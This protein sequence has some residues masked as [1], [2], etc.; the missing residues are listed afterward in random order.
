MNIRLRTPKRDGRS[1]VSLLTEYADATP[2]D[3]AIEIEIPSDLSTL[4]DA[5]LLELHTNAIQAFNDAYGDGTNLPADTMAALK[6]LTLGI[7]SLATERDQRA[8]AAVALAV[9]AA[10]LAARV[11][12]TSTLSDEADEE[13]ATVDGETLAD[14]AL[15]EAPAEEVVLVETLASGP[16]RL[17]RNRVTPPSGNAL[18]VKKS[19]KDVVFAA[20]DDF[21]QVAS[22]GEG[23]DYAMLG[24]AL[25]ERLG[26]F[27]V[28]PYENA[29]SMHR[30][31]RSVQ[32]FARIKRNIP[33]DLIVRQQEF[34][35]VNEVISRAT[36][37]KRLKGGSLV[38][39]GGWHAPS[40]ILY[41]EFLTLESRDGIMSLPEVGVTR[42]GLQITPGPSFASL[43]AAIPGFYVSEAAD[44]AGDYGSTSGGD[45][46]GNK[47]VYHVNP[48]SFTDYRLGVSGLIIQ[49]G[50][51]GARG[52]PE[53]LARV[54][55]GALVAHD[56]RINFDVIA[57]IASLST[58]VTLPATATGQAGAAAPVLTA[59]E[60]QVQHYR[61]SHRMSFGST[62]EAIFPAWIRGAIRSDLSRRLGLALFDV[63]DA[64]IAAW[65]SL[66]GIAPQF[67]YD[68]QSIDLTSVTA[69][70]SWP[71]SVSFLLYAVG[72]WIKGISEV[73]TL[74]TLYDSVLLGQNNFTA[75]FTEEAWFVAKAGYDS[76]LVTTGISPTGSTHIGEEIL[77]NG[78]V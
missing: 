70:T 25:D 48:P 19:M 62:L 40:E 78:T 71:T 76:R 12:A 42:G 35:H 45:T 51:L 65:F 68:W 6:Q 26:Q 31:L 30:E 73:L 37:Q 63:S 21:G 4:D 17:P 56:H 20:A 47:P 58:A 23:M 36:D 61:T 14:E 53:H 11:G 39:S 74:D 3:D 75:L 15:T 54:I 1:V 50:L 27:N 22:L 43:Y 16:I 10:E 29:A 77:A 72:T 67:V 18:A 34:G 52:Y 64:Q 24:R 69:F 9:E 32:H 28:T 59:I 44:I 60:L 41:N 38:A 5:A 7:E 55:S 66:R 33:S 49:S 8:A 46:A 57:K 13:T 2:A